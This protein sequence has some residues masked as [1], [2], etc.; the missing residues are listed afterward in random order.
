M[1]F[2]AAVLS[3]IGRPMSIETVEMTRLERGD[4]LV[5]MRASGL[6]H[7]DLEVIQGGLRYPLPIVLG[8]EGAG[9]VEA[10]GDGATAVRPGDHVIC[11]WNPHCG[12]CFYCERDQPI[13][14]EVF[15]RTQPAGHLMDGTSRLTIGGRKLHH[16][17]EVSSHAEY[18]VVPETGA[19][20]IPREMPFDRACLIGCGVMTGVGA[21]LRYARVEAGASALV[22]GCGAVGLNAVQGCRLARAEPVIAVD[23]NPARRELARAFGATHVVDPRAAGD[24]VAAVKALTRGRGADYVIECAG[25]EAGFRLSVEAA[26][27]GAKITWL[28]K[29]DVDQQV[30]FRWGTLMGERQITRSSYGGAR[31]MRDFPWLCRLYLEGELKLDELIGRRIALEQINE[32]FADMEKAAVVRTVIDFPER[33]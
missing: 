24:P 11:S 19:I 10:V 16:Y 25:N 5:R 28:G 29:T 31:P 27:P 13:L 8:H 26:R 30:S 4:V 3:E 22:I 7:T 17:S 18:A 21:A 32:G 20:P 2:R 12:H 14:C 9:V 15:A 33:P 1:K 6:C 23:V